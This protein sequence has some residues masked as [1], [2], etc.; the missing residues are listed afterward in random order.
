MYIVGLNLPLDVR[1]TAVEIHPI[2]NLVHLT[3]FPTSKLL[4]RNISSLSVE[5]CDDI[6]ADIW[7]MS[8]PCQPFTRQGLKKDVEDSRCNSFMHLMTV[9]L[10]KMTNLPEYL[11]VENVKGFE[12][13]DARDVM[14]ETISSL[15]YKFK[16]YLISPTDLGIPNSRLRY[17]MTASKSA[18]EGSSISLGVPKIIDPCPEC[19]KV[20]SF[21]EVDEKTP[22]NSLSDYLEFE[23]DPAYNLTEK[24]F[25]Y[26]QVMD[27]VTGDSKK[28][29]CFTKAYSHLYQGT[30]SVLRLSDNQMRFFTPREICNL[31]C[32]PAAFQFPSEVTNRQRYKLL[33]NSVNVKVVSV[34]IKSMLL[35]K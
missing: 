6:N 25:K 24:D 9:I 13:S 33:G 35:M 4:Q 17:Y 22:W 30:G 8:P 19:N 5:E 21:N 23:V 11:F 2:A 31:M 18:K 27:I 20:I 28:S 15:G 7:T 10:H 14:V 12:E 34:V 29:C 16:E 26:L 32:F 3:N 1:I